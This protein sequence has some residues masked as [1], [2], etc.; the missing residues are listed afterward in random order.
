MAQLVKCP[1][2]AQVMILELVGLRGFMNMS[3]TLG[4]VLKTLSLEPGLDSVSPSVS[5]PPLLV[6]CLS[7]SKINKH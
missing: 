5:A 7:R 1:T 3:P 2:L 6:L 4:S